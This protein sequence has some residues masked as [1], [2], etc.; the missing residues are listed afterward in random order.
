ML[1]DIRGLLDEIKLEY[2]DID[3]VDV[4]LREVLT[5]RSPFVE[6]ISDYLLR[7]KGK[8]IRPALVILCA[9]IG[10]ADTQVLVDAASAVELVHLASLLHDDV[11]DESGLRRGRPTVGKRW[12]N[13]VAVLAGDYLFASAFGLLAAQRDQFALGLLSDAVRAMCEGEIEQALSAWS[14]EL[15]E[16]AYLSHIG[17]KTASLLSACCQI[18]A[19]LAGGSPEQVTAMKEYGLYLGYAFQIVDD[20]LDIW[21]DE[22][23]IGKPVWL[24]LRRG[25]PTLPVIRLVQRGERGRAVLDMVKQTG[26]AGPY[27]NVHVSHLVRNAMMEAGVMEESQSEA[28]VYAD[29]A[30]NQLRLASMPERASEHLS[31]LAQA[32]V[33]Q[34]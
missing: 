24:D 12:G 27:D 33:S 17:K 26:G 30:I 5:S 1:D 16:T 10:S 29:R 13:L 22:D 11:I 31:R 7:S 8:G 9:T 2:P 14:D 3:L 19:H 21:G 18:G 4:R 15:D 20:L 6:D 28:Q 23:R 25:L 34:V 32:V